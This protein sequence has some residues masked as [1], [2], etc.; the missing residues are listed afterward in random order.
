MPEFTGTNDLRSYFTV[1][2]RWRYLL[3]AFL[4]IVPL[5]AY[6]IERGSN[7]TYRSSSLVGVNQTTVDTSLL[8]GSGT[9]S[10]TNVTAISQLVTTASVADVAAGLMQPPANPNQIVGE[11]SAKGDPNTNFITISAEDRSAIRAA[12]IA[13]AFARAI[14][15]NQQRSAL[16]LLKNAIRGVNTQ[17]ERRT[18]PTTRAQLQQQLSQLQA[19]RFTQGGDAAVLQAATPASTPEGLNAR[20]TIEIGL[21]IGLLLGLGAVVVAESADRRLRTPDD[22]ELMTELPLLASVPAT[23]FTSQLKPDQEVSET[24]NMLRSSLMYFNTDRQLDSVMITSPGEKDGKTTVAMRLA[25]AAANAGMHVILVDADLR[26]RQVSSRLGVSDR[27]GLGEVIAGSCQLEQA[28]LENQRGDDAPGK[29][30]LLPAG[31]PP[32]NPSALLSSQDAQ[33]VLR[34]LEEWSHLVVV[35]TPAALAVSDP[36]PLMRLVSGVIVVAR[37]NRSSRHAIRRLQRIVESAHGTIL[38]VV[39]TGVSAWAGYEQ[40]RAKY[41][42]QNGDAGGRLGDRLR[43]R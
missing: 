20:R 13:N 30:S 26:R 38:G 21:L 14:T 43:L 25:T 29:L 8:N 40:Y 1:L 34:R 23:A 33:Q 24:F 39:A 32:E 31:H 42:V 41:Y 16:A 9:F 36:L 12:A 15:L 11:V 6:L 28:L 27:P 5:I 2:W 18:N 19:A 37:M 3:L 35:D 4:V 7:A 10:T 17:L 22:L